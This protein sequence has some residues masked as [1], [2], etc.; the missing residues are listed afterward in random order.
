MSLRDGVPNEYSRVWPL[1]DEKEFC[2]ERAKLNKQ[3]VR[4]KDEGVKA[5]LRK[6]NEWEKREL[7]NSLKSMSLKRS[8][9]VRGSPLES[10]SA[11]RVKRVRFGDEPLPTKIT[12]QP[13]T[14][15]RRSTRQRSKSN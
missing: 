5:I 9:L 2:M 4:P 12:K 6:A 15:I 10:L 8:Q 1:L 3:R 14:E 11:D 13:V 7:V